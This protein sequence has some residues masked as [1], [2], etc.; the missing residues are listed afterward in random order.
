MPLRPFPPLAALALAAACSS[1]DEVR[2]KTGMSAQSS[3]ASTHASAIAS[4]SA[5]G[6]TVSEDTDLYSYEL[7]YPAQVSAYPRLAARLEQDAQKARAAMIAEAKA[8][9]AD[10]KANGFPYHP[11]SYGAKWQVVADL[12]GYLSLSNSFSSYSGGAHG[13]YGLEGLVW[14]KAN[15]RGFA[16]GELFVSPATLGATMGNAVCSALNAERE[17]RRGAPVDPK[18][19][20][21]SDCPGL[22]EATILA[23][24]SNGRTFDRITVWFGPYV[25]GSYAEGAYEIDFPMTR[26]MLEAVK[27]AYKTAFSAK[28]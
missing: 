8:F 28:S 22:D 5:K 26:A 14:D 19:D 21:F 11:Y 17:K 18:D 12:P 9:E 16:S 6:R 15:K 20:F 4:S 3:P 10:A 27:P 24:S 2:E 13:M 7:S 23:G 1:P 25:A